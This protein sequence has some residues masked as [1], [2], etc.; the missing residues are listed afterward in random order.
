MLFGYHR[1]TILL[2]L[3]LDPN[4]EG[5]QESRSFGVLRTKGIWAFLALGLAPTLKMSVD[6]SSSSWELPLCCVVETGV[7]YGRIGR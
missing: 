7:I 1:G 4:E 3:V 2:F 6:R 5:P